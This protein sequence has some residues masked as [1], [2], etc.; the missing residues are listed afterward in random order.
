MVCQSLL[1]NLLHILIPL[2][3]ALFFYKDRW[4]FS[5]AVMLSAYIID[6]DHLLASPVFD[7]DRCSIGFHPL[8]SYYAIAI[9]AVLCLFPKTRMI[10]AG[11]I[12]HIFVDVTDCIRTYF[13]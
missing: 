9:Y 6:I 4:K 12:I 11:L 7:P 10:G 5:W 8:H 13:N 1:H 2:S 3:A